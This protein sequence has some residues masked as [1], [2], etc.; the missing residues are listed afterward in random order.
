MIRMDNRKYQKKYYEAHREEICAKHRIKYHQNRERFLEYNKKWREDHKEHL[1]ER[2]KI[3]NELTREQRMLSQ[4]K[5]R[6]KVSVFY[7]R[8][9]AELAGRYIRHSYYEKITFKTYML[10]YKS[11]ESKK[12]LNRVKRG[13]ITEEGIIA[14]LAEQNI[15]MNEND[16]ACYRKVLENYKSQKGFI[17]KE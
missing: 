6:K 14:A 10:V 7:G 16:M 9:P 17:I 13:R 2:R 3:Y 11:G 12:I 15:Y 5:Y 8:D 4:K 1:K